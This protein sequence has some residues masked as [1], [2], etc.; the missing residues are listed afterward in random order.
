MMKMKNPQDSASRKPAREVAKNGLYKRGRTWWIR[1]MVRGKLYRKPIGPNKV[2]AE[3]ILSEMKK[4]RALSHVTGDFSGVQN[5]FKK[6][7]RRTFQQAADAYLSERQ[8]L[9]PSTLRSY[10]EILKNYLLPAFGNLMLDQ[11]TE[12]Q[13]SVFQAELA[14]MVSATRANNIMGPLRYILKVCLRRK[15]ID[16]N[17]SLEVK[18]L[19]EAEPDIDP[20]SEQ[21]LDKV[22]AALRA[23]QRPLFLCLAWTGARPD[24]MFALRWADVDFERNEIHIRRGRV[25]GIEGTPKTTAGSRVIYMVSLVKETLLGLRKSTTQHLDGY[26]FLNKHGQPYDR[27]I[28]REWRTALRKAGVRHRP[29]YQLRHTFAS[30]ALSNGL[31]PTWIAKMLGHKS[32]A[33]TFKHYARFIDD[34]SNANERQLEE[35]LAGRRRKKGNSVKVEIS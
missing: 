12:E 29:S 31:Q 8:H 5:F 18:R 32:A 3:A 25:R 34:A 22:I 17:P 21:E 20:L 6:P 27:H 7:E 14:Q 9:K 11:I 2:Q 23:Y 13:I 1:V 16:D 10:K 4:Q 15:F 28:D 30:L 19:P 24:E 35:Y 33:I 26:V